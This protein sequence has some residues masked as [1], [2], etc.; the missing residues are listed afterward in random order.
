M[1][2]PSIRIGKLVQHKEIS[3]QENDFRLKYF[4][5]LKRIAALQTGKVQSENLYKEIEDIYNSSPC[6]HHSTDHEGVI[7]RMNVTELKWLGYSKD[8]LFGKAK[9]TDLLDK[10]D[11]ARYIKDCSKLSNGSHIRHAYKLF[12]KDKSFIPVVMD[13]IGIFDERGKL[14]ASQATVFNPALQQAIGHFPN[15][16]RTKL[17]NTNIELNKEHEK[18]M[19]LNEAKDRF[20]GIAYHDLQ[21]P[22]AVIMLL[23]KI[24][25]GSNLPESSV[26]QKETYHTIYDA[27]LQMNELIKNYLNVNRIEKGLIV[28]SLVPVDIVKLIKNI[29]SRYEEIAQRKEIPILFTGMQKNVIITD[30]EC[31]LQIVENLLSNAIKF[32]PRG[33][34]VF[35]KTSNK[36]DDVIVEIEDEGVGILKEEIPMLYDKFQHLSSKPTDG[37][38]STGLGLSIVKFLVDQLKATIAVKSKVGKGTRF[39][40][41]FR[42]DGKAVQDKT[43]VK[44]PRKR[45]SQT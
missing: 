18:M 39:M 42:R 7:T 20:I 6:G 32:T 1:E 13:L 9:I 5:L 24:L 22:L 35:I 15:T 10:T 4:E 16:S 3:L 43:A 34:S 2:R 26:K 31:F 19:L 8:E 11:S 14:I 38:L 44:K 12:K 37:E 21:S 30:G 33:K 25:L 45:V 17:E 28:P 27:S 23:T 29:I 40:V 41:R 36:G